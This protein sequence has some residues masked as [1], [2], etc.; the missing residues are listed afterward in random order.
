MGWGGSVN[1][2]HIDIE[3]CSIRTNYGIVLLFSSNL[4]K[5]TNMDEQQTTPVESTPVQVEPAVD[6]DNGNV[7]HSTEVS[8]TGNDT[9]TREA[10]NNWNNGRRRIEQRQ[11][12]KARIKELEE[13]LAQYEGKD[14]DYSKF[15]REQISD[16]I[17]DMKAMNADAEASEFADRAAKWFG[18]DTEQ[19]MQ[20]TYRYAQYVNENEPDLLRY[21]QREY[22]PILLHEWYK[23]MDQPALRN[24]WLGMTAYEK[25]AVLANFYKQIVDI[26]TA[27]P[28]PQP[29]VP[30]PNGGRQS[31]ASMPTDD[32]GI[33]L[34]DALNRHSHR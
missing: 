13:R 15:Q 27:K 20:D 34:G 24:E 26:A 5:L 3:F 23:R 18:E 16:R 17:G 12:M 4:I 19:F 14:D 25:G 11:S 22:G 1:F 10:Q 33:A 7:Q 32:F 31:A 9:A 8:S 21:A 6:P 30:V 29:N 2:S 28:R